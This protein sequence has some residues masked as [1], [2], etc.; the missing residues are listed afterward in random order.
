MISVLRCLASLIQ[1][2]VLPTAVG[3]TITM[4]QLFVFGIKLIIKGSYK[5]RDKKGNSSFLYENIGAK[6][7]FGVFSVWLLSKGF[8]YHFLCKQAGRL[9]SRVCRVLHLS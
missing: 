4:R 5:D 3:P 7:I 8:A 6:F 2:S 9:S 1:R